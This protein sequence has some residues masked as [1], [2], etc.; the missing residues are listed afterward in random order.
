LR[1]A[2][3]ACLLTIAC[4]AERAAVAGPPSSGSGAQLEAPRPTVAPP[5]GPARPLEPSC[6]APSLAAR[7][8]LD[9][10]DD[11]ALGRCASPKTGSRRYARRCGQDPPSAPFDRARLDRA[12]IALDAA[13]RAH[14]A[15]IAALGRERGRRPEVFGLVGDSMTVSGAFLR[16]PTTVAPEVAAALATPIAGRPGATIIDYFAGVQATR[17]QGGWRDSFGA[18]RAAKVG[19]RAGWAHA[20]GAGS[21]LMQM[22]AQLSPASAVVLF[23][24][25]DAAYY[26]ARTLAELEERFARD[27]EKIIDALLAEGVIP[28]LNTLARHGDA[29]G[30]DD[31]AAG[32]ELGNWRIAVQTNA[33]SAKVIEIACRRRLP[34]IDVRDALDAADGMGLGPDAVHPSAYEAGAGVLDA[35]ALRC[36]Y[37][38]RS[39]VTLRMLKQLKE[40][41]FDAVN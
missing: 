25:N 22:V 4:D 23:G 11:A 35:A 15:Q 16:R 13:T 20:G 36:G 10:R 30:F 31:C 12:V 26:P 9:A 37:N 21:P 34:L 41:V 14:V 18:P 8:P 27:L 17:V 5:P 33:L 29:P 2:A 7:G 28:I 32:G 1:R 38:V 3:L 24:G 39:Y 40:A 19:A 6:G